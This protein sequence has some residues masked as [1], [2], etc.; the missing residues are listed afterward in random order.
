MSSEIKWIYHLYRLS[1]IHSVAVGEY[2][3][4]EP[5]MLLWAVK[6]KIVANIPCVCVYL[7]TVCVCVWERVSL[8]VSDLGRMC[9]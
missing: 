4:C 9:V 2:I 5:A 7:C 1:V 8:S 6:R 3:I